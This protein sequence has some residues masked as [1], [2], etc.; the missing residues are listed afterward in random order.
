ML[1]AVL[2]FLVLQEMTGALWPSAFVATVFA[3]HPLRAESVAWIAERKDVLSGVFF[4][5]TLAAH[6]RY[7][8]KPSFASY[9]LV[10]LIFALGLMSKPVPPMPLITGWPN[11]IEDVTVG[12]AGRA[13]LGLGRIGPPLDLGERSVFNAASMG[14][15]VGVGVGFEGAKL[16]IASKPLIT[17]SRKANKKRRLKRPDSGGWFC[18]ISTAF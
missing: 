7:V 18:C 6:L 5:L 10:A 2:L 3:I 16:S 1:A 11:V 8:R 14:P 12:A 4:M 17:Q 13:T 15:R 9:L